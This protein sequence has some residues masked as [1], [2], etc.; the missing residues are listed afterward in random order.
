M[1]GCSR[2]FAVRGMYDDQAARRSGR[3]MSAAGVEGRSA[4]CG[5]STVAGPW[6]CRARDHQRYD[7]DASDSTKPAAASTTIH[8]VA[9]GRRR[10]GRGWTLFGAKALRRRTTAAF[11]PFIDSAWPGTAASETAHASMAKRMRRK[12]LIITTSTCLTVSVGFES[13]LRNPPSSDPRRIGVP[14]DV[15]NSKRLNCSSELLKRPTAPNAAWRG[16][17]RPSRPRRPWDRGRWSVSAVGHRAGPSPSDR[18]P[19]RG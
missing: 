4:G 7:A 16:C 6:A 8:A 19:A 13:W 18:L 10:A 5:M 9:A 12:L 14:R 15:R 3:S 2:C 1:N 17:G 11:D